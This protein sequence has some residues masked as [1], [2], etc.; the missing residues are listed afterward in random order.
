MPVNEL[1]LYDFRDIGKTLVV[2]HVV[3]IL[4]VIFDQLFHPKLAS[5]IVFVL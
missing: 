2:Q 5:M 3:N 1:C 4:P